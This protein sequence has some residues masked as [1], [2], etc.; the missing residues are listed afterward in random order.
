MKN[1]REHEEMKDG[2]VRSNSTRKR[3]KYDKGRRFINKN[4]GKVPEY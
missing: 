3:K 2:W 1:N 4:K